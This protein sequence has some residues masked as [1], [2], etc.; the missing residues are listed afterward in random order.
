MPKDSAGLLMYRG[1][2]AALEVLLVHPGGPFWAKKD[3]GA[4]MLPKGE[5]DPGEEPLDAARREFAEETGFVPPPPFHFLGSLR[6]KSGKRVEAWACTG[7]LEKSD[8]RAPE[9]EIEWPPK[10]GRTIRFPE[11]DR[12]E[13]FPLPAAREK[14]HPSHAPFLDRL[15]EHLRGGPP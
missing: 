9:V 6:Q 4:W 1:A 2:G 15:E 7:P 12:A 3:A 10:S 5:I 11:V 13:F 14:I 8:R